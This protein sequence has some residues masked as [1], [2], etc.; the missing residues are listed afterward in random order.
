M[1]SYYPNQ[2][3]HRTAQQFN[4]VGCGFPNVAFT[5]LLDDIAAYI[6]IGELCVNDHV[7]D[8]YELPRSVQ[9]VAI[10]LE[11]IVSR[12]VQQC[13]DGEYP[14]VNLDCTLVFL[15]GITSIKYDYL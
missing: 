7:V 15:R 11:P 12:E 4:R 9:D 13:G 5:A 3:V 10:V 2:H 14:S 8:V 6:H 1:Y